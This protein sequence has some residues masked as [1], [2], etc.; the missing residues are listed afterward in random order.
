MPQLKNQVFIDNITDPL[1]GNQVKKI[2]QTKISKIGRIVEPMVWEYYKNRANMSVEEAYK[3]YK[4]YK[5][6]IIFFNDPIIHVLDNGYAEKIELD[7]LNAQKSKEVK[8]QTIEQGF[9]QDV[10]KM[11]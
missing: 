3:K 11:L 9:I 6:K 10:N 1:T 7:A 5:L 8:E 4:G 2:F